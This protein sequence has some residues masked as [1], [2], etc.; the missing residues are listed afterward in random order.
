MAPAR[1]ETF[2]AA[3]SENGDPGTAGYGTRSSSKRKS[4]ED[5]PNGLSPSK[6]R[7]SGRKS[8][9]SPEANEV[10]A[11]PPKK[12]RLSPTSPPE[13]SKSTTPAG[14]SRSP[15]STP[16][17][18]E[19]PAIAVDAASGP[20]E[21]ELS[22]TPQ[23]GGWVEP[24]V[25]DEPK[26]PSPTDIPY[27]PAPPASSTRGRGRGRGRGFRGGRWGK[28]KGVS[29]R[30]TPAVTAPNPAGVKKLG[31]GGRRGRARRLGD[32][33]IQALYRRRDEIK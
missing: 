8:K 7:L 18:S 2:D 29:E 5:T 1:H 13:T 6:K 3:Q 9:T 24:P 27:L 28:S 16:L 31:R 25:V 15:T 26:L 32:A 22:P 23:N 10:K 17:P 4:I 19:I 30:A 33:R 14:Q 12:P 20:S 11:P 21:G